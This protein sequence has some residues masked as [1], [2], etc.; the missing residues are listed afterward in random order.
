MIAQRQKKTKGVIQ[1]WNVTRNRV[2]ASSRA[3]EANVPVS[4]VQRS[5]W[6]PQRRPSRYDLCS[7][8][9]RNIKEK[10]KGKGEGEDGGETGEAGRSAGLTGHPSCG[11]LVSSHPG[12]PLKA[13]TSE[14]LLHLAPPERYRFPPPPHPL[15]AALPLDVGPVKPNPIK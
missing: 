2:L 13:Q 7:V 5:W 15:L 11:Y 9:T 8:Q 12:S 10:R 14:H 6:R 3:E 4:H 1:L